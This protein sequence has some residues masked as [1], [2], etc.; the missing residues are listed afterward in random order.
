MAVDSW[1]VL[2]VTAK[3]STLLG[4][5]LRLWPFLLLY[6]SGHS[7]GSRPSK[8]GYSFL[9]CGL[10][11]ADTIF[12]CTG[13][14]DHRLWKESLACVQGQGPSERLLQYVHEAFTGP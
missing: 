6:I 2:Q 1:T 9:A 13:Q 14:S 4:M 8:C 5:N 10:R 7:L 11:L 12:F 3:E